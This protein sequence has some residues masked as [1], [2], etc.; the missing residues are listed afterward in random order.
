MNRDSVHSLIL[1]VTAAIRRSRLML[2]FLAFCTTS[3]VSS[4]SDSV[5]LMRDAT[6]WFPSPRG[7]SA[8]P[9]SNL[10][11]SNLPVSN[12]PVSNLPVSNLPASAHASALV[13]NITAVEFENVLPGQTARHNFILTNNGLD[14]EKPI[15]VYSTYLNPTDALV[16]ATDFVG[17]V[18]LSAG[19]SLLIEARYTPLD[20][21]SSVAALFVSHSGE[22][23][24]EVLTLSGISEG[25]QSA[26][27]NT[28]KTAGT[29]EFGKSNLKNIGDIKPTSLQFGP[30]GRLYVA[31]MPGVIK[32]YDI[33]RT[34]NNDYQVNQTNTIALIRD[35]PNH[36]DDGRLNTSINNRRVTGIL[37]TGS[38]S[39]PVIYVSSSDPRTGGG[40]AHTDTGLDTNSG[41]ISRLTYTGEKWVK[42]D[43]VRGL[44]RSEKNHHVNGLALDS[45]RNR[46]FVAVGGNTNQGVASGEFANLPEYALSAAI[47][48]IDLNQIGDSTYDLPTLD[49]E[50]RDGVHDHNDPFGGN[51]GKNQAKLLP[52]SPV[53]IYAPGFRNPY[54]IVLTADG[55]MYATD[56]G[57]K[58]GW[59]NPPGNE[60]LQGIC[61]NRSE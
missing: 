57:P 55:R 59:G 61:S 40:P 8:L 54:D 45:I 16:F 33:Q 11:A 46:L 26:V 21:G 18:E 43:L 48:E 4:A 53:Q 32:I 56:N 1:C 7:E 20:T 41:V 39:H 49:D 58:D 24:L 34:G 51:D 52:G 28:V 29:A 23:S 19:E 12:L 2:A 30:D 15:T 38:A 13:S 60:G 3:M 36:N 25:N 14:K 44:P 31:D 42:L 37:V 10:P 47:L 17:P 9:A 5:S 6:Q 27:R 35:M 50:D 22:S